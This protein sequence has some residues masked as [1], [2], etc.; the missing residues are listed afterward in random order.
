MSPRLRKSDADGEG[1]Y[2]LDGT[3][4][5]HTNWQGGYPENA[6]D[7]EECVIDATEYYGDGWK[8]NRDVT[9]PIFWNQNQNHNLS[10][11]YKNQNCQESIHFL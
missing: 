3:A 5:D 8:V 9:I 7:G 6:T 11:R 10:N 1:F 4:V 2:W